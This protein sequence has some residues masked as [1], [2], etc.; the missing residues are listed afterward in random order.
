MPKQKSALTLGLEKILNNP[1]A[2][3]LTNPAVFRQIVQSTNQPLTA[4]LRHL[5]K[6]SRVKEP[7]DQE[8]SKA[9]VAKLEETQ[10]K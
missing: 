1:Q 9:R 2:S 4:S 10:E 5:G 6:G 3:P 8:R 7:T